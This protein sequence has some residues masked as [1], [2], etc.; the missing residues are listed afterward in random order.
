MRKLI[1]TCEGCG[2]EIEE[3]DTFV[4]EYFIHVSPDFDRMRGHAKIIAGQHHSFSLR[5][6]S[7]DFCLPCYNKGMSAFFN[8]FNQKK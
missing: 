5:K 8:Q 4:L 6:T 1:I 7:S 2:A 3:K